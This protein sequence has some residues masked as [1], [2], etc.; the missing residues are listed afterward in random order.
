MTIA[1]LLGQLRTS[2][3]AEVDRRLE[4][5]REEARQ[6]LEVASRQ[7]ERRHEAELERRSAEW[8]RD[9]DRQLE[10]A[11]D[12]ASRETLAA[13]D[14]LVERVLRSAL[15][16]APARSGSAAAAAWVDDTVQQAI[17]YLPEGPVILRT[18]TGAAP[19]ATLRN[20]DVRVEG[21]GSALGVILRAAD[22]AVRVEATFEQFLRA[23]RARL[24][25]AIVA[26]AAG[27][28]P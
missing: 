14:R 10:A 27:P 9:R 28:A 4:A 16:R 7:H 19:P 12:T 6:L 13:C 18:G 25:Q 2:A 11:R 3:Q 15:E 17:E 24:A 8:S 23:G 20:R 5:A 21:G 22:G 1:P 26:G